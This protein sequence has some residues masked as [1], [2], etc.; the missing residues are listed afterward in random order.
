MAIRSRARWLSL[1]ACATMALVVLAG[2]A[3]CKKKTPAP[4]PS[5]TTA[6]APSAAS[7][8]EQAGLDPLDAAANLFREPSVSIQNVVK[9][10]KTWSPAAEQWWGKIA[11]D[12][13]LTDI[14]G[15]VHTLSDYRGRNVLV[16]IWTTWVATCRLEIP[17][18]KE[19]RAAYADKD[20]A[21]LSISN[22]PPALLKEYAQKENL[23][24]TVLSGGG[25]SLPAPFGEVQFVPS[26]FFI[27]PQ[28]RFKVAA[29]GLVPAEDAKAIVQAQ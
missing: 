8:R 23:S 26:T 20:L 2:L 22:E 4:A 19:L 13:T 11:Q 12:F 9:A 14:N 18:L 25:S 17:H 3:G 29:T 5:D 1:A 28:G 6:E 10:A 15:N 24:F 16:V 7:G 27:D 21:I